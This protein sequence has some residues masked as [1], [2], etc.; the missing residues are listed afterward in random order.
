VL[1][2]FI[3]VVQ[4]LVNLICSYVI[5]TAVASATALTRVFVCAFRALQN[6]VA[7]P[8]NLVQ[9]VEMNIRPFAF[10]RAAMRPFSDKSGTSSYTVIDLSFFT[11]HF[12]RSSTLLVA[13]L[14]T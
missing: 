12:C 10:L 13:T 6:V 1:Q 2:Q 4:R 14:V 8:G 5:R 7:S 11:Q 3:L 9:A